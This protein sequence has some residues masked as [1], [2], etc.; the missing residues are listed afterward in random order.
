V[1]GTATT[2]TTTEQ[3]ESGWDE[4]LETLGSKVRKFSKE[5][6][7]GGAGAPGKG[8]GGSLSSRFGKKE[9]S[10]ASLEPNFFSKEPGTVNG[11]VSI[12]QAGSGVSISTTPAKEGGG[13]KKS[14]EEKK[15][16]PKK[17]LEEK[18]RE[19]KKNMS[20]DRNL[21]QGSRPSLKSVQE[22]EREKM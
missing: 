20:P 18:R 7:T 12:S 8:G 13:R 14:I 9:G 10:K 19:S 21:G 22:V 17:G 16:D 15:R 1:G 6:G 4:L 2:T 5:G 3:R 11:T